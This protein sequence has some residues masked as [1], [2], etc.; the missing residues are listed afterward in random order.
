[1]SR[2]TRAALYYREPEKQKKM[3]LTKIRA[4]E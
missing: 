3:L 1:M 4:V 2:I